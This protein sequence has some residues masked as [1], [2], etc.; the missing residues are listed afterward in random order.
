MKRT[1]IF[2]TDM[3]ITRLKK[4]AKTSGTKMSELIRRF[5][6]EGLDKRK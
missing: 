2:L 3:Q 6:D 5:I 1:A 4:L